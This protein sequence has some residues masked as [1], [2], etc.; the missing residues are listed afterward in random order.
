MRQA[1]GLMEKCIS[2]WKGMEKLGDTVTV[3]S[4]VKEETRKQLETLA[5]SIAEDYK[6][7]KE[8]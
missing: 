3:L 6:E 8:E 5:A 2:E 4:S 7:G 1:G